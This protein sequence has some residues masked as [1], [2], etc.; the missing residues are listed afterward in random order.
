MGLV[1]PPLFIGLNFIIH[2]DEII[3]STA[4]SR[5]ETRSRGLAHKEQLQRLRRYSVEVSSASA[6]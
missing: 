4:N 6:D 5:A 3:A 2:H 1:K